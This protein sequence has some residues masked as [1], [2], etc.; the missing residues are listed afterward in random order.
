MFQYKLSLVF[1]ADVCFDEW[2]RFSRSHIFS[3][4]DRDTHWVYVKGSLH[5]CGLTLSLQATDVFVFT[6]LRF[7]RFLHVRGR[8]AKGGEEQSKI[9]HFTYIA[10]SWSCHVI[11]L[12]QYHVFMITINTWRK[13]SING[14][15]WSLK[16]TKLSHHNF[17]VETIT[18]SDYNRGVMIILS[19]VF[20]NCTILPR[21][22]QSRKWLNQICQYAIFP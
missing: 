7:L 11:E 4:F 15:C 8:R 3:V 18:L 21:V 19:T 5:C 6:L 13:V 20:N 14:S 9:H 2:Q 10:D 22:H 17:I 12:D 1:A 16:L